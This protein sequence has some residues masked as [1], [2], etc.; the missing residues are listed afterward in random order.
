MISNQLQHLFDIFPA[1]GKPWDFVWHP[2][3]P[4]GLA[5]SMRSFMALP[6]VVF[7]IAIIS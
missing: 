1:V 5:L 6:D 2:I 4:F 3:L 7:L